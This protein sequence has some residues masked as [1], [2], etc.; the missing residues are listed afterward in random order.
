MVRLSKPER[1]R[2]VSYKRPSLPGK[3]GPSVARPVKKHENA[4]TGE[5]SNSS[6][7]PKIS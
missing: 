7:I 2:S 3:K 4:L 1:R 5:I 6:F